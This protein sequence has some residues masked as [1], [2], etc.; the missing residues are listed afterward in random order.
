[1]NISNMKRVIGNFLDNATPKDLENMTFQ[2]NTDPVPDFS[3]KTHSA[4]KPGTKKLTLIIT[5]EKQ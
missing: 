1:M 4:W 2:I 3:V 5:N